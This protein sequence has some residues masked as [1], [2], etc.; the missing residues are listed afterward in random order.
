MVF[1][2]G[3]NED[4]LETETQRKMVWTQR[5]NLSRYG[6]GNTIEGGQGPE[7]QLFVVWKRKHN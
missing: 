3:K 1:R 2:D 7:S 6:Y 4:C 5:F